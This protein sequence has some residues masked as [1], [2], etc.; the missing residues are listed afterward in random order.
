M[1]HKQKQIVRNDI[2]I[3]ILYHPIFILII[4]TLF[5]VY[6]GAILFALNFYRLDKKKF[7]WIIVPVSMIYS[8]LEQ[9]A[10]NYYGLFTTPMIF[11]INLLG[12]FLLKKFFWDNTIPSDLQY[13]KR[14]IW[15]PLII[16][17][18]IWGPWFYNFLIAYIL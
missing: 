2:S 4:G 13:K 6:A 11:P 7:A 8:A 16:S 9:I 5:A 10:L 12:I 17:I 18:V 1:E 3:Q 14:S 15:I